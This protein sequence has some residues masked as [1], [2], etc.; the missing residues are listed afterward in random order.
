MCSPIVYERLD[1]GA[2]P[3]VNWIHRRLSK[4]VCHR[5]ARMNTPQMQIHSPLDTEP[6]YRFWVCKISVNAL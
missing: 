4:I 3:N 6:D 2:W 5:I 1:D